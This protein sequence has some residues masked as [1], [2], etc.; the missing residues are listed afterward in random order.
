MLQEATERWGRDNDSKAVVVVV[1]VVVAVVVA[2]LPFI[3]FVSVILKQGDVFCL[4]SLKSEVFN[5]LDCS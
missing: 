2:T 5:K 3:P 4:I 1:V